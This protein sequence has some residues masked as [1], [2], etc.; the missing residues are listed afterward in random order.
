ML[1]KR[2]F[3]QD[4]NF[5][6]VKVKSNLNILTFFFRLRRAII[7]IWGMLRTILNL[8]N[9]IFFSFKLELSLMIKW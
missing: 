4:L 2:N 9:G 8:G 1:E 6:A 3:N 7:Q 5:W